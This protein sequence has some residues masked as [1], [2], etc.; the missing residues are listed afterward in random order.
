MRTR[1][2]ACCFILYLLVTSTSIMMFQNSLFSLSTICSPSGKRV[3]LIIIDG[4]R[5]DT[6]KKMSFLN[7]ITETQYGFKFKSICSLPSLSRPGYERIL[8]GSDTEINGINSNNMHIPSLTPGLPMLCKRRGLKTSVCGYYWIFELFPFQSDNSYCYY[9]RDGKTFEKSH[10]ILKKTVPDFIIVHPMSLDNAG[11][12]FGGLSMEYADE[13]VKI[14]KEVE[15][16]WELSRKM[17]YIFIVTS[18]HGHLDSGGHGGGSKA[19]IETPLIFIAEN[20]GSLNLNTS[21]LEVHQRDIA[22]T[23]CSVLGIPKTVY[24]TGNSL[25]EDKNM[26]DMRTKFSGYMVD[27]FKGYFNNASILTYLIMSFYTAVYLSCYVTALKLL[28]F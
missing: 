22:P 14:D 28:S 1:M 21:K 4:L 11:H 6:V 12:A 3:C 23:I 24:M 25:I 27:D 17:G 5:Y 13:A 15:K 7:G 9:I 10:M 19:E 18:D 2:L 16:L 20:I 26:Q 8:T